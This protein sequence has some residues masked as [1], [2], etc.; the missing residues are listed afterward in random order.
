MSRLSA[1][2]KR[3]IIKDYNKY[4]NY[5][6]VARR[7]KLCRQ[8]VK[9]VVEETRKN[10][11]NGN[12]SYDVM[13][14]I[15]GS[16]KEVCELI[17]KYLAVMNDPERIENAPLNQVASTLGVLVDKFSKGITKEKGSTDLERV[18]EAVRDIE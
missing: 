10:T 6:E 15:K 5:S 2:K 18:L 13:E 7:N 11:K 4:G 14:H 9:R 12:G 17:D 3:A 16:S 1:E 8:T